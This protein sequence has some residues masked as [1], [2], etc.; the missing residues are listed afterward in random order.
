M[1]GYGARSMTAPL[2]RVLVRAPQPADAARWREFGWRAEPD[3]AAAAAEHEALRRILADAGAEVI[4]AEGKPGNLERRTAC[5][6]VDQAS[7]HPEPE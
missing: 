5:A 2:L 3:L 1:L 6:C 7:D 4:L